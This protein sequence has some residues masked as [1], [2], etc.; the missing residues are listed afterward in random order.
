MKAPW[1]LACIV[2][3][4]GQAR[5]FGSDKRLA[6]LPDGN[7]LLAAS[8]A[9]VPEDFGCR[10]V[11]LKPDDAMLQSSLPTAWQ[12]V[13][14]TEAARGMGFSLQAGLAAV[15]EYCRGV[16][17]ALG[18]MPG[19]LAPTWHGI[20]QLLEPSRLVVPRYR[21]RRG[22]PVGIGRDFFAELTRPQGDS[23][24]RE[25]FRRYPDAV[26]WLDCEDPGILLDLD[27]PEDLVQFP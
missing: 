21:G 27:R 15:P 4:A 22:N 18:D 20:A 6:R 14:A 13:H 11:V 26:F 9:S 16:V 24:A 10:I 3:A 23:G 5:R 2:L 1:P 7:T 25:L 17:V 8:L 19:V 12:A